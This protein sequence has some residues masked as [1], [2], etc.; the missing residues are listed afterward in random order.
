MSS[1]PY[2]NWVPNILHT[3][4][5]TWFEERATWVMA[6][7]TPV[8]YL[9]YLSVVVP[10]LLSTS[11]GQ[12][13]YQWPLI[14]AIVMVIVATIVGHIV[15]A[16]CNPSEAGQSDERDS[17]IARSGSYASSFVLGGGCIGALSLATLECDHFWIANALFLSFTLA[18]L[19]SSS[20][21]PT[22]VK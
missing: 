18:D 4:A 7:A 16:A 14:A 6:A 13:A 10:G 8:A 17:L 12:V 9:A 3:K 2:I 21:S 19:T 5:P 1:W 11:A 15:I 22:D 20:T